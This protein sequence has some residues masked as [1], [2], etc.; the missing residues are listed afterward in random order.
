MLYFP[1]LD[2][3]AQPLTVAQFF[4]CKV[5][6]DALYTNVFHTNMCIHLKQHMFS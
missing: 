1:E 5:S 4:A 2:I 3:N 6:D